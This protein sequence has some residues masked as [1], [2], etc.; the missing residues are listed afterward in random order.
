LRGV[1]I[2]RRVIVGSP[3][4][5]LSRFVAAA[6]RVAR[7][8]DSNITMGYAGRKADAKRVLESLMVLGKAR[9][10][11]QVLVRAEGE[12]AGEAI[13]AYAKLLEGE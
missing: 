3:S 5:R 7:E 4:A 11:E 12:D 1:A 10:G 13:E 6:A 8:Y 9:R 2:E